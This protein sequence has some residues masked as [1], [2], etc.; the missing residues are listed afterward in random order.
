MATKRLKCTDTTRRDR[1]DD[2]GGS[3]PKEVGAANRTVSSGEAET[4]RAAARGTVAETPRAAE[5][6][7]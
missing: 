3:P 1:N 4:P 6:D 7:T 2:G 5:T